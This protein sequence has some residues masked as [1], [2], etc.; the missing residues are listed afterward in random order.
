M[1]TKFSSLPIEQQ[2]EFVGKLISAFYTIMTNMKIYH[3]STDYYSRHVSS[4]NFGITIQPLFDRFFE[5]LFGHFPQAKQSLL[6]YQPLGI[7]IF[8]H[9]ENVTNIKQDP[10]YQQLEDFK[11]FM[12]GLDVQFEGMS[13]LLNIRDEITGLVKQTQ[14]L[15][16]FK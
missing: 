9:T 3:W 2:S 7:G 13:D 12:Q 6:S 10:M 11:K 16:G 5:V 14:Y 15:F 1:S 8:R 4:D